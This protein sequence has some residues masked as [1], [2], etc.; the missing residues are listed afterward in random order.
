MFSP[1]DDLHAV[2]GQS[3]D[4]QELQQKGLLI[5]DNR[6][7]QLGFNLISLNIH[8]K[9]VYCK[10]QVKVACLVFLCSCLFLVSI[11]WIEAH[12]VFC[13]WPFR[14]LRCSWEGLALLDSL[15]PTLLVQLESYVLSQG[16]GGNED[17]QHREGQQRRWPNN[18]RPPQWSSSPLT[19]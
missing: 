16:R 6:W 1:I 11:S 8:R 9:I 10:T 7:W 13:V 4:I 12:F 5:L 15:L 3:E 18:R 14:G 19:D 17:S 2:L